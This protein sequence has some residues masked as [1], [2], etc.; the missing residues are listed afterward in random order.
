M[1][2][3]VP[4]SR[5][6]PRVGG[7]SA[8][9][10]RPLAHMTISEHLK[11][12]LAGFSGTRVGYVLAVVSFCLVP[13]SF[14]ASFWV[15]GAIDDFS[16]ILFLFTLAFSF[17]APQTTPHRFRPALFAFCALVANTLVNH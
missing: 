15:S 3:S 9:F 5:F 4:L 2:L 14:Y 17:S 10:V 1:A 7:G 12:K 16:L 8:F 6:T 13:V 11:F